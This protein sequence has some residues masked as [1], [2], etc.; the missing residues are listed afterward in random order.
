MHEHFAAG[1][2]GYGVANVFGAELVPFFA[3]Q[4][5]TVSAHHFSRAVAC[6][7]LKAGTGVNDRQVRLLRIADDQPSGGMFYRLLKNDIGELLPGGRRKL[8]QNTYLSLT[9]ALHIN[10]SQIDTVY[11]HSRPG[12]G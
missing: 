12:C 8:V 6:E 11:V 5:A 4:K 9:L 2:V 10:F 1:A 7:R 3:L